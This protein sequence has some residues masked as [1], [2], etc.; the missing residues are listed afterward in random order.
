MIDH[1]YLIVEK[2]ASLYDKYKG[3]YNLTTDRYAI[4]RIDRAPAD[5]RIRY[6]GI[7]RDCLVPND[8]SPLNLAELRLAE[9]A[10]TN[11]SLNKDRNYETALESDFIPPEL[12]YEMV[13]LLEADRPKH[14]TIFVKRAEVSCK[15]PDHY[16]SIGY[17]PSYF[18]SDHFS[19]SCDCM[20]IPRW[21]GTD[22]EGK[23]FLKYFALLNKFGLFDSAAVAQEFLD[24]YL[25]LDW[26]ERG[27]FYIV[28]VFLDKKVLA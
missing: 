16:I 1:G 19:A 3:R 6:Q 28:E 21:H 24:Y 4:P 22:E 23:L 27:D 25:S 2:Y 11:I 13:E 17:E 12:L 5:Y 8:I 10:N 7:D 15:I 18:Y 14:E 20:L 9:I 26:T